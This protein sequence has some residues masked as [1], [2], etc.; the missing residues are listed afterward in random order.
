MEYYSELASEYEVQKEQMENNSTPTT[1]MTD[2]SSPDILNL[3]DQDTPP[4]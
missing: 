4:T 3:M 2:N 1:M